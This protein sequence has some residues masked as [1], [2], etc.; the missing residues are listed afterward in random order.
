M[1]EHA[2]TGGMARRR[3]AEE[4]RQIVADAE[5]LSAACDGLVAEANRRGG[6]DNI[7]V[8]LARFTGDELRDPNEDRITVELPPMEEDRTLDET[9]ADTQSH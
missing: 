8:V 1:R 2:D 3:S 7:T 9:E 5:T 4:I 6:E